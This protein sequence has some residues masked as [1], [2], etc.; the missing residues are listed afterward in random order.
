MLL[1]GMRGRDPLPGSRRPRLTWPFCVLMLHVWAY[2]KEM[3]LPSL[4]Q[5]CCPGFGGRSFS[6]ERGLQCSQ[7][8]MQRTAPKRSLGQ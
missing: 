5:E 3:S 4:G 1:M 7:S 2:G 6:M 8:L